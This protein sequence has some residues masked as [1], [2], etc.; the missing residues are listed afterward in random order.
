MADDLDRFVAAQA[1][2]YAEALAELRRGRKL[3]HWMW[4]VFPQLA[5]LGLSATSRRFAIADAAEARA[6]L[7]HP[8]LGP[9]LAEATAAVVAATGTAEVILGSIDA[10]KLRSS[11]TLFAVVADDAAPFDTALARFF[12]GERDERTLA[13]LGS[14]PRP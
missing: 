14:S 10:M 5:G 8:L 12:N 7:A 1:D 9:R 13:L 11:L 4:W 2:S 6:Y 3:G